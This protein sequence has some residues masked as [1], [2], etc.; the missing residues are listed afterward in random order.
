LFI[1]YQLTTK[2][3]KFY[4]EHARRVIVSPSALFMENCTLSGEINKETNAGC[5][6]KDTYHVS[7]TSNTFEEQSVDNS[8][9]DSELDQPTAVESQDA[10]ASEEYHDASAQTPETASLRRSTRHSTP[11]AR[12]TY[13][14]ATD[15]E[16]AA[17]AL[18][19]NDDTPL[20]FQDVLNSS[21]KENWMAA[22]RS[23]LEAHKNKE[24]W[25]LAPLPRDRKAIQCKWVFKIKPATA[26]QPKVYKA[27]LVAKGFMQKHG[28]DYLEIYSPTVRLASVRMML[29]MGLHENHLIHQMD[30]KTAFLNGQIEQE[31]YME[32]PVGFA[33]DNFPHHVCKLKKGIYGLKQAPRA[34]NK[35][36][37]PVLRS[38]GVIR[39][40][41]DQGI[42][43]GEVN[44]NTVRIAL[45]VD[46][47]IISSSD[48]ASLVSVKNTL[49]HHFDMKDLGE[50]GNVLGIAIQY[51]P[52]IGEIRLSQERAVDVVLE[53][54]G[55]SESKPM[56]TP[57]EPRVCLSHT[58]PQSKVSGL[59]YRNA[60]GSIMY[61]MLA[62]R[63]DLAYAVGRVSQYLES[64]TDQ[65]W[66]AV[67]RIIRYLK[68]TRS[69]SLVYK[70]SQNTTLVGYSD[71]DWANSNDRKS[72]GGYTFFYG[73]ALI[74]WSS[75]KQSTIALSSTEA[76]T[77]ALNEAAKESQWLRQLVHDLSHEKSSQVP[78]IYVDNQACLS[79]A[80]REGH[81]GRTKHIDVKYL[82]TQ[83]LVENHC[84]TLDYC[85]TEDM[86][87]DIMTKALENTKHWKFM[88]MMG[89]QDVRD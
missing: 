6:N 18:M 45:Y 76:E 84:L 32:Q 8:S 33:D 55:L 81:H 51:S 53:K 13:E 63:P 2:N 82:H 19:M 89:I 61:L 85:P 87:A 54:F 42:Y 74:D 79:I 49:A 31:I 14:Y 41:V 44:G 26:T 88:K 16:H 5:C 64:H 69:C 27:R 36:I 43:S 50:V 30:V 17:I 66:R 20:E 58:D 73:G 25:E 10:D 80:K 48:M 4:D 39:S 9:P 70:K 78:K 12:L 35:T 59:P 77:I 34:W 83:E 1:G 65:H 29:A 56:K 7:I 28:V 15:D 75:R 38:V 37:D 72:V 67:K 60:V 22:I 11:P 46:D 57:M 23:E 47:L 24:T 3:Y 52:S 71:S 40:K 68:H 21:E 62:T 86:V